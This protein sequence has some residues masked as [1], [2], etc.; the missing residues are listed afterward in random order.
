MYSTK[1][2]IEEQEFYVHFDAVGDFDYDGEGYLAGFENIYI[3]EYVPNKWCP[4]EF[5][6]GQHGPTLEGL[7]ID[8]EYAAQNW[9]DILEQAVMQE[10]VL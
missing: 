1:I 6:E 4:S 2:F 10:C 8:P 9:W 5:E 3:G 7:E